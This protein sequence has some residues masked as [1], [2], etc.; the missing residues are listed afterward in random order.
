MDPE[1]SRRTLLGSAAAVVGASVVAAPGEAAAYRPKHPL[2]HDLRDIK[3]IVVMMQEN[4]SFDHYFGTLRGV[5][6][7]GDRSYLTQPNGDP[8]WKQPTAADTQYP[9]ALSAVPASGYDPANPP[10]DQET[11]AQTF[12]GTEHGWADQHAAWW[13]GWMNNWVA[14]KGTPVTLGYLTRDDIPF[15]YALADA[16]TVGDAYHCSTLSSTGPNRTYLWSGTINVSRDHDGDTYVAN[17]G[18]DEFNKCGWR[19]YARDLQQAG[20]DWRVYQCID[21]YGDSG[22]EYSTQIFQSRL[23]GPLWQRGV[24]TVDESRH[25]GLTANADNLAA[26]IRDDVVAGKLPQISYVVSNQLFSEHPD[27]AAVNG[28]YLISKVLEALAA[29]P[30]VLNSTA[31]IVNYDENDG[32]FDHVP[33][34]VSPPGEYDEWLDDDSWTG[35]SVATPVG[36]GFRVPLMILSPWTRGGWVYSETADHTSVIRLME[37][38]TKAIGKPA[39]SRQISPWRR[40]VCSDLVRAFDFEHPVY[41]LPKLPSV[42]ADDVVDYPVTAYRPNPVTNEMPAQEPGTRRARPLAYQPNASISV[43]AGKATIRLANGGAF[44]EQASHFAIYDQ[45]AA[46]SDLGAYPVGFPTQVTVDA[47]KSATSKHPFAGSVYDYSV[48][49]PNRFMR[50]FSGDVSKAGAHVEAR[51]S[52]RVRGMGKVP[53]IVV[54]VTN[55]G[56]TPAR[57]VVAQLAYTHG[58][59]HTLHVPAHGSVTY[60]VRLAKS[61]GWYDLALTLAGDG[62]W[63]RRFVGH[64]ENGRPSITG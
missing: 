36:L 55:H 51:V 32:Q 29:D 41:G 14:A 56:A 50:R 58:G 4:R 33:P 13:G 39:R 43:A 64:V 35:A 26:A 19:F 23:D 34:P 52:Y 3:H 40:R 59:S 46:A 53:S 6:G 24:A 42:T 16:Y 61:H 28:G 27:A 31:V 18:G 22:T 47:K 45:I 2:H 44:A 12:S 8:V 48:F 30:D 49:G 17:T 20:I 60:T 21:D 63:R 10:P 37:R 11:G 57:V 54:T 62:T 5:R 9:Y 25:T 15:H 38:W 7:F 1:V